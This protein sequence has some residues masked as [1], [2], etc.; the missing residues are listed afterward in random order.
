MAELDKNTLTIETLIY[1]IYLLLTLKLAF[2]RLESRAVK[3]TN[4]QFH[5]PAK[6]GLG[7]HSLPSRLL[8]WDFSTILIS[9]FYYTLNFFK[10]SFYY[11]L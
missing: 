4:Q 6:Q 9:L 2:T 11:L 10:S 8:P 7:N 3:Q 5:R 1:L